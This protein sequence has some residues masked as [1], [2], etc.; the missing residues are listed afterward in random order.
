MVDEL[1]NWQILFE[2]INAFLEKSVE[3]N[4]VLAFEF[5]EPQKHCELTIIAVYSL[6]EL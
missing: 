5:T 4:Q 1:C 3:M 2:E 6:F